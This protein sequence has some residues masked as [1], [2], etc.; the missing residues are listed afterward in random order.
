MQISESLTASTLTEDPSRPSV[1]S[2][3]MAKKPCIATNSIVPRCARPPIPAWLGALIGLL[4]SIFGCVLS[5]HMTAPE[6]TSILTAMLSM[7]LSLLTAAK[8]Y[9]TAEHIDIY[10]HVTLA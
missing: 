8:D 4:P 3:G 2:V 5:L 7:M 9:Y 10:H 1:P 6:S